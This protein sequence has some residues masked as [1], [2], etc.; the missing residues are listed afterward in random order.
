MFYDEVGGRR[1]GEWRRV[2]TLDLFFSRNPGLA[3]T[4]SAYI[5]EEIKAKKSIHHEL[6]LSRWRSECPL[7]TENRCK[8]SVC[9]RAYVCAL[10]RR[11]SFKFFSHKKV[12]SFYCHVKSSLSLVFSLAPTLFPPSTSCLIAWL[13]HCTYAGMMR[14]LHSFI[15]F[16][17]RCACCQFQLLFGLHLS[18]LCM[19]VRVYVY[20]YVGMHMNAW[21]YG[22]AR[23]FWLFSAR[24]FGI[25]LFLSISLA[26]EKR[27]VRTSFK[28]EARLLSMRSLVRNGL[29]PSV[30]MVLLA[31][32]F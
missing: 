4:R 32:S 5:F 13:C 7:T 31:W 22:E 23:L 14:Y 9:V 12:S 16:R 6:F 8:N 10:S 3:E 2:V 20:M 28:S 11:T 30:R 19:F 21:A 29:F 1:Q 26:T 18:A 27:Q 24:L 15:H 17:A 25:S